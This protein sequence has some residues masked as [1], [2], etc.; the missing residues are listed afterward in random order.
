[1]VYKRELLPQDD[2][3]NQIKNCPFC[4][5]SLC[6]YFKMLSQYVTPHRFTAAAKAYSDNVNLSIDKFP[7]EEVQDKT[8]DKLLA[9]T[10][11][12]VLTS[13]SKEE[14]T[15]SGILMKARYG[16]NRMVS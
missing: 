16:W 7:L 13:H 1:M 14:D 11:E 6:R 4:I 5:S 9:S 2:Q 10:E 3:Y 12:I 15:P 8:L